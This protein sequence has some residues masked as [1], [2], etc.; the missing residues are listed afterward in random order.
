MPH[1]LA[2]GADTVVCSGAAQSNFVRQMGAAC[3]V[4]GLKCVAVVMDLPHPDGQDPPPHKSAATGGNIPLDRLFGVDIRRFRD[5]TWNELENHTIRASKELEDE[6]AKTILV[7]LGGCTP[8]SVYAF[9]L[10]AKEI[11][12]E[13]D[14]LITPCSSGSTHVGLAMGFAGTKTKVIGIS[15]DPEPD[16]LDDLAGLSQGA[17]D[18]GYGEALSK[19]RINFRLDWVGP[20]Y[21]VPSPEGEQARNWLAKTEGVVLD[22]TYSGKAF[23][24]LLSMVKTK[25]IAG[26]ILFWHTGG[27]P[28]ACL[29]Q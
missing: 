10:A 4:F 17:A 5:G 14:H 9:I 3:A 21:G 29:R 23:S 22:P 13:F 12:Q 7:P 26:R 24:G 2:S 11:D 8:E 18:K 16:I 20:G 6:G 19:D 25:T 15:C 1:I 27:L 28:A